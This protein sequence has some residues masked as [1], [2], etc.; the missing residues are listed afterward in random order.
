MCEIKQW[1]NMC[2]RCAV[3]ILFISNSWYSK[4]NYKP[5]WFA[6]VIAANHTLYSGLGYGEWLNVAP[7]ITVHHPKHQR[8]LVGFKRTIWGFSTQRHGKSSEIQEIDRM[9]VQRR[10]WFSQIFLRPEIQKVAHASPVPTG[11]RNPSLR[12]LVTASQL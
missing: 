8:L 1:Y 9:I 2:Y 5:M 3:L 7:A 11:A 12:R 10:S 6:R 4:L